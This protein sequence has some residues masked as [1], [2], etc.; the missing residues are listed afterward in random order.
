MK[1]VDWIELINNGNYD[2]LA[3][4]N[5]VKSDIKNAIDN[6]VWPLGSKIF[7]IYPQSGKLRGQGNGVKPIKEGF[8]SY[9]Q[10]QGWT[11]EEKAG[12]GTGKGSHPGAF[13][14]H[15][16]FKTNLLPF[17]VEWETGN[18]SSSHRAINRLA[19]GIYNKWISGGILILPTAKLAK[20]LTDRIGNE[21]E[22]RP[23]MNLWRLWDDLAIPS[24]LGIIAIEHDAESIDV[25][26]IPKGTDGLA[27]L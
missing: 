20:F 10:S 24:Y 27:K 12:R 21:P 11:L 26:R 18:I 9:L 25:P 5:L 8:T 7:T 14:C 23:Y 17:A 15:Y 2:Q 6:V 16:K 4:Y 22:L 3:E 13:D 19:L 1:I